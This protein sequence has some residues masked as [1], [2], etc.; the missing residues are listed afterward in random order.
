MKRMHHAVL[1]FALAPL[2]C[3]VG[4]GSG[5][6]FGPLFIDNCKGEVRNGGVREP[7]AD[8]NNPTQP[9]LYHLSPGFFAAEPIQDIAIGPKTNR[10]II[11]LQTT[12]RRREAN[13]IVRFDI[14]DQRGVARCV[15][16]RINADGLPDYDRSECF[17][18]P[19]GPRLRVGPDAIIHSYFTPNFTC[20]APTVGAAI[21]TVREPNDGLWDSWIELDHFGNAG[22]PD[23]PAQMRDPIDN[24]FKVEFDQ[25]I[26][27]R[28]LHL[29]MVDDENA[30]I[31]VTTGPRP[32][33]R[34]TAEFDGQF[35][36]EMQR[37]QG[38]QT[39]P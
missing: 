25:R 38:A 17:W 2:A 32:P 19:N 37:G 15:R 18:G 6:V 39:F 30:R 1:L 5:D 24:E 4:E 33:P 35:D 12:G 31:T 14:P 21:S 8:K 22:Q 11:R 28:A 9:A 36:F 29:K 23:I 7:F 10:L 20:N 3:Q 16:G 13:D 26:S 34:L 27:A